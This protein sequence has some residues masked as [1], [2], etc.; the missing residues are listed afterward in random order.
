MADIILSGS[1]G[2][3]GVN[4]VNDVRNVQILLNK[5]RPEWGGPTPKLVEDGASGPLTRAA[6]PQCNTDLLL[7]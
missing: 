7:A 2:L 6:I 4:R 5:V 3:S 1:V